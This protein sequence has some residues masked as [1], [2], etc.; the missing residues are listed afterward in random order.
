MVRG[1]GVLSAVPAGRNE[2]RLALGV[3]VVSLAVFAGLAPFAQI[4]LGPSAAFMPLYQA[5]LI[6]IDLITAALLFAQCRVSRSRPL[7]VLACG[8][9][10]TAAMTA[11]HTLTFPG[12]F[13]PQGLLGGGMQS[14]AWIYMLWHAAFPLFVVGYARTGQQPV[15]SRALAAGI[16]G[17]LALA[18]GLA[19]LAT[20][21]ES[22]LP[23]I[24]AGHGYRPAYH[25][26][27]A[28]VWLFS[29]A[30]FA[31]L[32]RKRP[33]TVLDL[34]VMVVMC[35]W[36]CEIALAAMLNAGR[37]DLGFYAGR[38]YGLAAASFVLCVLIFETSA[39]HARLES[40][41]EERTA[42]A[43]AEA[44]NRAKDQFL[45]MLG[46]ELRN[47]LAPM[48]TALQIM[49][50]RDPN[51]FANERRIIERQVRHMT[52][53]V[54]DLLDVSRLARGRIAL[55]LQRCEAADVVGRALEM[56]RPLIESRRHRVEVDVASG[57]VLDADAD[58]L[59][60]ALCNLLSN[61]AKFTPPGGHI[62]VH[63]AQQG[64]EI[65]L[66]VRD[67][68]AGISPE[69]RERLFEPFAQGAQ[70]LARAQGGLGLG[71][72]I[73]RELATLHGGTVEARSDG[74]SRGSEFMLRLPAASSSSAPS[75]PI[76]EAPAQTRK[77]GPALRV[78]VVDDNADAA[79]MLGHLL[80]S[81][82]LDVR[83]AH[84][85]PEALGA[86]EH[87]KPQAAFLDLGLPAMDGVELAARLRAL[88]GLSGLRLAALT[89]YGQ[90]SDRA[91]TAAAGFDAH[92]VKPV[93]EEA[94]VDFLWAPHAAAPQ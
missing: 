9:L 52:R 15:S 72:A 91:R 25:A 28:V 89:G 54:D 18:A 33:R 17:A 23:P 78:L 29:F 50:M 2:E 85:G 83:V 56:A 61:A 31:C 46:H 86:A 53:L 67:N 84:D 64:P 8:Y 94:L 37:F 20:A 48:V 68:G 79:A 59:T 60:Q 55:R 70:S 35:A 10:F 22:L 1:T 77:P 63:A 13:A 26:V 27:V 21:G 12:L 65:L 43:A 32:W 47:P 92:F 40:A 39:L 90:D 49:R 4:P 82:G 71:L 7:F 69:L 73:V 58:R 3:V 6:L 93:S 5:A 76:E 45:A 30:A 88:P 36:V 38:I 24:M 11:A 66:R 16:A 34:W 87:F 44:A 81:S 80:R 62:A 14:T 42:R 41:A 74:E 57:L 75:A 19:A 51:A